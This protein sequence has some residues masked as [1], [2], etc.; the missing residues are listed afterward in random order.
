MSAFL[1]PVFGAGWQ[2]FTNSGVVLAG[3]KIFTYVAGSTT[4]QA[5]WTDSTQ[6]VQ[7]ANPI[8]LDSA[9]RIPNEV[10]LADGVAY[11]FVVA[12]SS[13]VPLGTAWDNIVG[14]NVINP[15][16][17]QWVSS[18]LLPTFIDAT[19]FSVPSDQTALFQVNRRIQYILGSGVFY[20]YVASV[21]YS[22][23]TTTVQIVPDSVNLDST[24][25]AVNYSF[26]SSQ[27]T[28]IPQQFI[29]GAADSVPSRPTH[30][31]QVLSNDGTNSL[32]TPNL[33]TGTIFFA[34][35]SDTT[36]KIAFNAA[37]I[38]T[39]TTRT[40]TM[41]DADVNL[42]VKGT[43]LIT[44]AS[45]AGLSNIDYL[46]V[47]SSNTQY[48]NFIVYINGL[49]LSATTSLSLRAAVAG[50]VD[51]GANYDYMNVGGVSPASAALSGNSAVTA[52]PLL[53][54]GAIPLTVPV[55]FKLEFSSPATTAARGKTMIAT[56]YYKSNG[57]A[58]VFSNSGSDYIA[59]NASSGFRLYPSSGT[60]AGYISIYGVSL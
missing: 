35:S 57:P 56:F 43:V 23:P 5:T 58:N 37:S 50:V 8:I 34:D 45:F 55:N 47:F 2:L 15:P 16:Q 26:I 51:T 40:I 24:L 54:S 36:K 59:A 25:S 27:N 1:S 21:M 19:H 14:I 28:S 53:V 10:W 60:V 41:P 44:Q 7:N 32:W 48:K 49:S 17:S 6:V 13:S 46:T 38:T 33:K 39:A 18:G 9:G 52:I 31:D 12:D 3:G 30:T 42:G 20:G 22:A 29:V 4:P 11:K